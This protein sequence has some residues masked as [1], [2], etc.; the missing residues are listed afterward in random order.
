[1]EIGF[2]QVLL[3]ALLPALGNVT[4]GLHSE[5]FPVSYRT[6]GLALHAATG[7]LFAV[8]GVELMPQAL[9]ADP[10]WVVILAFVLGGVVFLL[11]DKA[12][13]WINTRFGGKHNDNQESD[14]HHGAAGGR[15]SLLLH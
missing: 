14:A 9:Q 5:L 3:L 1:M 10:V 4:G 7:I 11:I 6:L 8:I 12:V 15:F 13:D 2:L